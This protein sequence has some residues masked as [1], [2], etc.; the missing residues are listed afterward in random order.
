MNTPKSTK[1]D[2]SKKY[3]SAPSFNTVVRG[4]ENEIDRRA[5]LLGQK[6]KEDA[7]VTAIHNEDT[8]YSGIYILELSS[9]IGD[10]EKT[11]IAQLYV[12][13]GLCVVTVY[14]DENKFKFV[15]FDKED[16]KTV[17]SATRKLPKEWKPKL[18][19]IPAITKYIEAKEYEHIIG[20]QKVSPVVMADVFIMGIGKRRNIQKKGKERRS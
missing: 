8:K 17:K 9:E 4:S 6:Y 15:A 2:G 11:S 16:M 14:L 7:V 5:C 1:D 18:K 10:R 20:T 12:D 3:K 13:A 19:F